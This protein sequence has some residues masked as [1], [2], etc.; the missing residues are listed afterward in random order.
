[1][2]VYTLLI[3]KTENQQGPTVQHR[4][5]CAMSGSS[6]AGR[7]SREN[8]T[9]VCMASPFTVHRNDH[10]IVNQL[11]PSTN[12][13]FNKNN[14]KLKKKSISLFLVGCIYFLNSKQEGVGPPLGAENCLLSWSWTPHFSESS[15]PGKFLSRPA[16]RHLS[17]PPEHSLG[18]QGPHGSPLLPPSCA[19]AC[20][21]ARVPIFPWQPVFQLQA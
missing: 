16:G 12:K 15:G 5:L 3:F 10:Q 11:Y 6:L 9:C 8:G 21:G 7:S 17:G 20:S 2:D 14:N 19:K 4:E 18:L 13:A 1:M